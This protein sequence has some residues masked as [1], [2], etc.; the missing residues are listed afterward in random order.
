MSL[1]RIDAFEVNF[2]DSCAKE[3]F[4][5]QSTTG[6]GERRIY[7]GSDENKYDEFFELDRIEC[8]I[9]QKKD[10]LEYLD[11]AHDEFINPTQ[12]Y[13]NDLS[14][15]YETLL[16]K[17]KGIP[18]DEIT[19]KFRKTFDNQK[20]YYLVLEPQSGINAQNYNHIRNIAL[21]RITKF[22]FIKLKDSNTNKLYIY[23]R[24]V[25]F[26][27]QKQKEEL[28]DN[29][30][31]DN[32]NELQ[33]AKK[34]ARKRQ[35]EYRQKLLEQMPL[36]PFTNVTEDRILQ[37]CH[38]KPFSDCNTDEE[39]Y[40]YK[41]GITMTPTYHILFDLGMI[42]FKNN[43]ELLVSPFLS[44]MNKSRLNLKEGHIYRIQSGSDNYLEYH[45]TNVFCKMPDLDIM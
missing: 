18:V 45:R 38:I 22:C 1:E 29:T 17:T 39:R 33:D 23:M 9:T 4:K 5:L 26:N 43:G 37:A 10:L 36:C 32:S 7:V 44:N 30:A 24:P 19:Y 13:R 11:D 41:N 12:E 27:S 8:F 14:Q 15:M 2:V 42:S 31:K 35:A 3:E 25:F 20:R 21:P 28:P 6:I 16:Q 34:V 40:D